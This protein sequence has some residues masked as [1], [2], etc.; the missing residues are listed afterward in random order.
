MIVLLAGWWACVHPAPPGGGG[1]DVYRIDG[2]EVDAARWERAL[3]ALD[4]PQ[5]G[6]SC[7]E[8]TDGGVVSYWQRRGTGFVSV[9]VESRGER[10][11]AELRVVDRAEL[12]A[13]LR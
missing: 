11:E 4:G 12:P 5:L 7:A 1:G 8:T 6:W 9:V 10:T 13:H 2:V 3:A